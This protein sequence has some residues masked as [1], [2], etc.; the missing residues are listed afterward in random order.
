MNGAFRARRV[1][2]VLLLVRVRASY[3]AESGYNLTEPFFHLASALIK[4]GSS[5]TI[6]RLLKSFFDVYT[7]H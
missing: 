1:A 7:S 6:R 5:V 2:A 4:A 3:S